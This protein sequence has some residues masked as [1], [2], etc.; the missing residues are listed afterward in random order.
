MTSITT[1]RTIK[2][3][4]P[5]GPCRVCT[6]HS[7]DGSACPSLK[8]N[9]CI[10][11]AGFTCKYCKETGHTI[12][13]CPTLLEREAVKNQRR[14][15]EDIASW[16]LMTLDEYQSR[17][18]QCRPPL[19][20]YHRPLGV[21]KEVWQVQGKRCKHAI[22]R[23]AQHQQ[24]LTTNAFD[25]LESDCVNPVQQV[26]QVR[27][28]TEK[29]PVWPTM[30]L[31]ESQVASATVWGNFRRPTTTPISLNMTERA[32]E[33]S[34]KPAASTVTCGYGSRSWADD[35][36]EMDPENDPFLQ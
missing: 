14:E 7:K 2:S 16:N 34:K 23:S 33:K 29:A 6:N 4:K 25:S 22:L 26:Q 31:S 11:I 28:S 19:E 15:M 32:T 30:K 21:S 27:E 3:T 17:Q 12:K 1:F 5:R 35:D 10:T 20:E 36:T 13:H 8:G 24:A 9:Q 18:I